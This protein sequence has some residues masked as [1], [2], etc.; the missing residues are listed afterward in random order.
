MKIKAT[1]EI[2]LLL[3]WLRKE[4]LYAWFRDEYFASDWNI[5]QGKGVDARVIDFEDFLLN[6]DDIT[7]ALAMAFDWGKT[8]LGGDFWFKQAKSWHAY[9]LSNG[10]V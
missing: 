5:V 8:D 4:G 3:D 9:C 10:I 2:D 7:C 6:L 1:T